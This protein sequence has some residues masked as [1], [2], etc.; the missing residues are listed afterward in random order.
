[1]GFPQPKVPGM[2]R[3]GFTNLSGRKRMECLNRLGY[4]IEIKVRPADKP[5]GQ[6]TLVIA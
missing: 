3:G 5:A 4:G 6:R 1:M 2:M